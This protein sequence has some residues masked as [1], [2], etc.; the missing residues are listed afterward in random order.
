G[1]ANV[2]QPGFQGSPPPPSAVGS[3]AGPGSLS[4]P[5]SAV[6]PLPKRCPTCNSRYPLD[7]VVC[8]RDATTLDVD[9]DSDA[10]PLLG[11]VL[12]GTYRILRVVGEGGMGKVY[13]AQHL[14][15]G[16]R[17]VAVKV[18][19]PE[20][21]RDRDVVSRFQKEAESAS[22]I[23][24]P[25]VIQ[26]FD[27]DVTPDGRP[28]LVGEFLEGEELGDHL[29]RLGKID[30]GT[31]VGIA[32]QVCRALAAAHDRGVVHRDMKP[33]NVFLTRSGS[34][35]RGE[36]DHHHIK[37]I[38]FGISKSGTGETHL[39]RTG[40]IIGTP[41]Y[42]APEQARGD[43]V[44]ARADVYA[45][46]AL[47][48]TMLTGQRP[49]DSDD[50]TATLT[51]VLTQ[52]PT[53][54][55]ELEPNIPEGLELVVQRAMA[56]D[57]SDRYQTM[58]DLEAALGPFDTMP[59][60]VSSPIIEHHG[61]STVISH[62][63]MNGEGTQRAQTVVARSGHS[64]QGSQQG[65]A[66]QREGR[67]AKMARPTIILLTA[68]ITAWF[69][70]GFVDALGGMVR[71]FRAG[72]ITLSEAILLALGSGFLALTPAVLFILHVRKVVWP[73]SVKALELANDLRR[74]AIAAFV[75]YG[76]AAILSRAFDTIVLRQS[77]DLS[78]GVWD[79]GLFV[80][81]FV[82]ALVAGGVG[83]VARVRRRKNG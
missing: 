56:K 54:P 63:G 15:I 46:G 62:L 6:A 26:V 27:V 22:S 53:R 9:M 43:K 55:R 45:T 80:V 47:L 5:T 13:E 66:Q 40:M 7:F 58:L 51:L 32:R 64:G 2:G 73:N 41:A 4:S 69:L 42:M 68:A 1:P 39:T 72:D 50:P 12:G 44:D 81:S 11:Q 70:V 20:Y 29:D 61:D 30:I 28:Y 24:H 60:F 48:Y 35:L 18:L 33:E 3:V 75:G 14:R 21:A 52:D 31:A 65:Y 83:P 77:S 59:A 10:D 36:P 17:K 25:N 16:H 67:Q 74:T 38:D 71:I 8:P 78:F 76:V 34:H 23:T 57:A 79:T 37:V 19:H 49:F 82:A